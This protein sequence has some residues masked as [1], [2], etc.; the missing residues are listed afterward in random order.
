MTKD[1]D[2]YRE[3]EELLDHLFEVL[4]EGEDIDVVEQ[5]LID[6]GVDVESAV[7]KGQE[8]V[9]NFLKRQKLARGRARY[10]RI[11]KAVAEFQ[12]GVTGSAGEAREAISRAIAGGSS[13]HRYQVVHRKLESI[14]AE[15]LESLTDDAVL[16]EFIAGLDDATEEE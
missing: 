11:K 6:S 5:T 13:G 15:D 12:A 1:R 14:T 9:S 8:L 4:S 16:S 10:E 7:T 3:R 2:R